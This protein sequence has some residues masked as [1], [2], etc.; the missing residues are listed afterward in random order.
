MNLFT[1][2][3][4]GAYTTF[5]AS[6]VNCCMPR[7]DKAPRPGAEKPTIIDRQPRVNTPPLSELQERPSTAGREWLTRTKSMASRASS[8]RS[9]AVKRK[10]NAYNGS[11]RPRIGPPADFRHVGSASARRAS[12][13]G[14][15]R[16][17]VLS[18]HVPSN[19]LSP[20]LPYFGDFSDAPLPSR[21]SREMLGQTATRIHP[22]DESAVSAQ[23]L[24][25][26][27]RSGSG[28]SWE[29][30]AQ[31]KSRPDSFRTQDFLAVLENHIP[32]APPPARLRANTEPVAYERVQTAL[33]EK[34]KLEQ[35][36]KSLEET[37]EKRRSVYLN[38][39][40]SASHVS[41]RAASIYSVSQ[42]PMP[43]PTSF[44]NFYTT[45][46]AAPSYAQQALSPPVKRPAT[47]QSKK[48][49]TLSESLP[50]TEA[51]ATFTTP[52]HSPASTASTRPSSRPSSQPEYCILPPPPLPLVLQQT[53][54][55][56]GRKKSFSR[57]SSW[58][59]PSSG[60]H[61]R[62][63]SL[64][65][66][67]NNPRPITIH[68]GFYQC[69]IQPS[70]H[71]GSSSVSTFSTLESESELDEPIF[72]VTGSPNLSAIGKHKQEITIRRV[73]TD[74]VRN[75]KS[76]EITRDEKF[77][78]ETDTEEIWKMGSIP[79]KVGERDHVGVAF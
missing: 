64:D 37:I 6:P 17:L 3:L 75:R 14:D 47:A 33:H 66:V 68:D 27:V 10:L 55:V 58:L 67:T 70:Q 56:L 50:W 42:E 40:L 20:I 22:T 31:H 23:D 71:A 35:R 30:T 39:R 8:R 48:G 18:I 51:S 9:F 25:K 28:T 59:F 5:L 41:S 53:S 7:K 60:E 69:F 62:D 44:T 2:Y 54:P 21:Y 4:D 77:R 29:S 79:P 34:Y 74:S 52:S 49:H 11:R 1:S 19:K 12:W 45:P 65:S 43:S 76:L 24:R 78:E 38:D 26:P 61:T 36:V 32:I 72:P 15:F 13:S 63:I 46:S 16:P 73:S 57:V